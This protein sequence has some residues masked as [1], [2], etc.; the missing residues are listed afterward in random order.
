MDLIFKLGI[1]REGIPGPWFCF[2][3]SPYPPAAALAE[4]LKRLLKRRSS[5]PV[6]GTHYSNIDISISTFSLISLPSSAFQVLHF[7]NQPSRWFSREAACA[8]RSST[9]A[10]RPNIISPSR[11][12]T[13]EIADDPQTTALCHCVDC[14]KVNLISSSNLAQIHR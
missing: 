14:Q 11:Q 2:L 9:R 3:M 4:T 6:N 8:R 7:D 1:R 13:N 12:M 10:V 5:P